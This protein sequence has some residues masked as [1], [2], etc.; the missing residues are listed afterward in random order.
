MYTCST[1][2]PRNGLGADPER[3]SRATSVTMSHARP[4][5]AMSI[6]SYRAASDD[7]SAVTEELRTVTPIHASP[8]STSRA[9]TIPHDASLSRPALVLNGSTTTRPLPP[10]A[11]RARARGCAS[12]TALAH[13]PARQA[14]PKCRSNGARARYEVLGLFVLRARE[15][16]GARVGG[17]AGTGC[18]DLH[19]L[20]RR[21][22]RDR[23]RRR[24]C[25]T[26]VEACGGRDH[27]ADGR[28]CDGAGTPRRRCRAPSRRPHV[29]LCHRCSGTRRTG[30][31]GQG[32][33]EAWSG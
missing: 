15:V 10:S 9:P 1:G 28:P 3:T 30:S 11:K 21:I 7:S 33:G 20:H 32:R 4:L 25:P 14:R 19:D 18:A 29:R 26:R 22:C 8:F 27:R 13:R 12:R 2:R 24:G 16:V 31:R 6:G 23:G 17:H 5:D